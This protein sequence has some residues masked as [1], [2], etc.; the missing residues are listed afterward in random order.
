MTADSAGNPQ[1][2]G[3]PPAPMH[4]SF[5]FLASATYGAGPGG[6]AKRCGK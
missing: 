4:T 2:W 3:Q 6:V 1:M 5:T